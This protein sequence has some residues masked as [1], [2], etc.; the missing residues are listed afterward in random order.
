MEELLE[1]ARKNDEYIE[2]Y[3]ACSQLL[4]KH[5]LLVSQ[6]KTA[7]QMKLWSTRPD[8]CIGA[9]WGNYNGCDGVKRCFT[10][11][12]GDINNP[13]DR[14][15][16]EGYVNFQSSNTE[17]IEIADDMQTARGRWQCLGSIVYG[18]AARQEDCQGHSHWTMCQYG[19]DFIKE[20]GIWKIWHILWTPVIWSRYDQKWGTGRKYDS[21]PLKETSED[22]APFEPIYNYSYDSCFNLSRPAA[23]EPYATFADVAPGYGYEF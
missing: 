8:T 13:E 6:G 11:D 12:M 17:F 7:E 20:D 1:K 3:Y 10:Q 19:V 22:S 16:Y 9:I 14:K 21:F 2:A 15:W 23:P 18:R 4:P 5:L